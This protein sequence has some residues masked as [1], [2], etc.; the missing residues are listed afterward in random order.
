MQLSG[1][2]VLL[3]GAAGGIGRCVALELAARGA[4]TALVDRRAEDIAPIVEQVELAGGTAV[5]IEHDLSDTASLGALAERA[6]ALLGGVDVLINNA[7]LLSFTPVESESAASV[8]LLYR[9]N[10]IAPVVLC[11][12]MVRRFKS[13]GRGRIV[14]VGSIFGSIGFAHFATYSSS[15]FAIRGYSEA[16]RRELDGTGIGVT[17]VAP[18]ATRTR[19]AN[20]F[21]RMADAVGMTM[22]EPSDVAARIVQAIEKDRRDRYLGQPESTFVRVN[23]L[24]PRLVDA[25]TRKQNRAA[26][27]YAVEAA[28][29]AR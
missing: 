19:L 23:A 21:G 9:V 12:E 17:Y 5:A 4:V 14:N 7:G 26:R 16:L 8:D 3:T 15:K 2:R 27:P 1:S 25:A 24:L 13:Q 18:R 29:E 28:E 11:G 6:E 20:V 10:V 22:D